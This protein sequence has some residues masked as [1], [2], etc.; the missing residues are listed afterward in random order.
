MNL[1]EKAIDFIG[2]NP[3]C[4]LGEFMRATRMKRMPAQRLLNELYSDDTINKI[5]D[6]RGYKFVLMSETDRSNLSAD[7]WRHRS[8]AVLLEG[9]GMYRRAADE[10]LRAMDSTSN[11]EMR[12]KAAISR[13]RCQSRASQP[14][15]R[16]ESGIEPVSLPTN[17]GDF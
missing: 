13:N 16:Y 9:S 7:Y 5:C 2:K 17:L 12:E 8:K 11:P 10:W 15:A 1:R 14:R 6:H 4:R 3:G